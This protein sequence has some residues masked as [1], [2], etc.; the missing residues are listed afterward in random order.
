MF[1]RKSRKA[2]TMTATTT[3]TPMT[4]EVWVKRGACDPQLPSDFIGRFES[5]WEAE[6]TAERLSFPACIREYAR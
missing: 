1:G 2:Q 3:A 5:R 6:R 4:Y